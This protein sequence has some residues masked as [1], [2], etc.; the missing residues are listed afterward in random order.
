LVQLENENKE[1]REQN[2]SLSSDLDKIKITNKELSAEI[3]KLKASNTDGSALQ[4]E[5]DELK[6]QLVND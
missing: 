6:R 4:S 3:D 5:L 1:L 2:D